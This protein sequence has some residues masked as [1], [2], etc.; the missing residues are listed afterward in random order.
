MS[1]KIVGGGFPRQLNVGYAPA[2]AGD[3]ASVNPRSSVMS[4]AGG[5]VAGLNGTAVGLFA[6]ADAVNPN[7]L[8]NTGVGLPL[9][10]V[11]RAQQALIT[12]FLDYA[13]QVVPAGLPVVLF[14]SGDFWA[15]NDGAVAAVPGMKAYALNASGKVA[16]NV[17][18]TPPASASATGATLAKIV[19]NATGAALPTTN[20]ITAS[21]AG[22][23]MTV[24]SVGTSVV[25]AGQTITSAL[26][27]PALVVTVLAQLTGS[28]GGAGTYQL[29]VVFET[30]V[31]SGTVAL[32]GGSLTLTGA[33]VSGVFAVGMSI[34]GTNVPVGTVI[35]A[36]VTGSGGAGTYTTNQAAATAVSGAQ[37]TA[38]NAMFLTVDA[39]ST[40]VWQ[41]N[42]YLTGSG[43]VAG[44]YIAATA[45]QNA[46]LTGLGGAGTYLT[47]MYQASA[48]T[49]QTIGVSAGVET[50]W[51]AQS[52]GGVGE[53]VKFK[54]AANV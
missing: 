15:Q 10:F 34:T 4:N 22:N 13:T 37:I 19:S 45:L 3:F 31:V 23:V 14:D 28:A 39:S 54:N 42:D 8:N 6:W 27:D 46:T 51:V 36:V 20:N 11:H 25:A 9:G 44:Q 41:L 1:Q 35:T 18:G 53:L 49:A 5:H 7:A 12:Q 33:N 47:G 16:F 32:S 52:A 40:G 29:S 30:P 2:V 48:L 26:L 50:T 17:T 43:V 21:I 38:S 24:T